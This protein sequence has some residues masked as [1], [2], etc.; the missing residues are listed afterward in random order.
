MHDIVGVME[1]DLPTGSDF[2]DH[3]PQRLP[4]V[5][6]LV[7]WRLLE[8]DEHLH[9][10]HYLRVLFPNLAQAKRR[11]R[12]ALAVISVCPVVKAISSASSSSTQDLNAS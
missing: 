1:C 3:L 10:T 2:I 11:S 8:G 9:R 4:G 7:K 5:I 6:T 12:D